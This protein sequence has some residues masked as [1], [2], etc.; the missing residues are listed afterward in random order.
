MTVLRGRPGEWICTARPEA[1]DRCMMCCGPLYYPVLQWY[2]RY[3]GG[4]DDDMRSRF[5]CKEC[6]AE[7][8]SGFARDLREMRNLNQLRQ[9]G[10]YKA[11]PG[12]DSD[13][14]VPPE[15]NQH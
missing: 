9:L 13:V 8:H 15:N 2:P 11:E 14:F 10:F 3:R 6:C 5:L 1:D 7:I 12:G 4:G